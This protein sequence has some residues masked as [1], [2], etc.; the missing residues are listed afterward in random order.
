MVTSTPPALGLGMEVADKNIMR[1]PPRGRKEGLFITEVIVDIFVYGLI[2]G[3]ISFGNYSFVL[4]HAPDGTPGNEYIP[5]QC[6]E[7]YIGDICLDLYRARGTAFAT[8]CFLLLLHAYNCRSLRQ[9]IDLSSLTSNKWLYYSCLIGVVTVVP[10]FYIPVVNTEVFK[11]IGLTWQ[12]G[13]IIA[14]IVIFQA[15]VEL[16]KFGK[17]RYYGTPMDT[18]DIMANKL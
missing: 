6:N 10:T 13:L 5:H 7:H 18:E 15:L 12:W 16:Y 3:L 1:H 17:R 14:G 4:R 11:H 8:I 9:P 2:I